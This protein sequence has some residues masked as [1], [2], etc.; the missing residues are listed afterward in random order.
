MGRQIQTAT[1]KKDDDLFFSFLKENYDVIFLKYFAKN[2]EDLFQ[3]EIDT[4][5][6]HPDIYYIWNK[7][8]PWKPRFEQ[9]T[10]KA[11]NKE[12]I[13]YWYVT[14][15][16]DAPLIEFI[17]SSVRKKQYGR[18]YWG[19]YFSAPNGLHYDVEKFEKFYNQV[20]RWFKKHSIAVK[21]YGINTYFL[22]DAWK[23]YEKLGKP[24]LL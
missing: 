11:E 20:I 21:S 22:P 9:I 10:D 6:P 8:F 12:V 17:T 2:K 15:K 3:T 4:S 18:I 16:G 5:S 13:G 19:K 24:P 14:N 7:T 23:I 1:T